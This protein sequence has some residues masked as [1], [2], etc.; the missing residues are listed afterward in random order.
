VIVLAEIG[1]DLARHASKNVADLPAADF[2]TVVTLCAEE[3]CPVFLGRARRVHWPL[4]DPAAVNGDET[5]RLGAFRAVRD[6]LRR[7]IDVF[8]ADD[9]A[10]AIPDAKA[11]GTGGATCRAR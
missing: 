1:I 10:G 3:E 8:F 2:D 6:E 9:D 4:P 11:P 7:R 5:A